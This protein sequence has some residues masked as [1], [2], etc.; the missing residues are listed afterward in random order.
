MAG[1]GGEE[2]CGEHKSVRMERGGEREWHDGIW[3]TPAREEEEEEKRAD[4]A[5]VSQ[6]SEA[7]NLQYDRSKESNQ[8]STK[9]REELELKKESE[10]TS[11]EALE[12]STSTYPNCIT[13]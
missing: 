6:A 9:Y 1:D 12:A 10:G 13:S 3:I 5:K 4:R 7:E 2:G 8:K 11:Q